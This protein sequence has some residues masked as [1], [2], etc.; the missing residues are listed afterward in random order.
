VAALSNLP[1]HLVW[2]AALVGGFVSF[3]A[4]GAKASTRLAANATPE[5]FSN[6]ILSFLEDIVSLGV[7][8]L[9]TNYPY[10]ALIVSLVL[11]VCCLA[12]IFL[13]YQF[14]K[15]LVFGWRESKQPT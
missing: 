4:H 5:P 11:L 7:L 15:R 8:W 13:F 9:V 12:L 14:F 2:V 1:T 3:S 6:W 10:A